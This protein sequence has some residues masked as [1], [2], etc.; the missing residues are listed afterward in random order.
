MTR[1]KIHQIGKIALQSFITEGNLPS[2]TKGELIEKINNLSYN[3]VLNLLFEEDDYESSPGEKIRSHESRFK[4]LVK[5]GL[6]GLAGGIVSTKI[7]GGS[8]V[9]TVF[10]GPIWWVLYYLYRKYSDV[11]YR[12]CKQNSLANEPKGFKICR[13]N[14]ARNS[15]KQIMSKIKAD[16]S[17][18]DS[19]YK[20]SRCIRKLKKA[21]EKWQKKY[22]IYTV[23]LNKA[24]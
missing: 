23:K 1:E 7:R 22:E 21:H 24:R 19:S 6:A 8:S 5:Y 14:C 20:P 15:A 11:C 10:S 2:T 9:A 13:L 12:Q 3:D 16:I 17:K 4:V 18:C